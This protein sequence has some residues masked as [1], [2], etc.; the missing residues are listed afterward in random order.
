MGKMG[1]SM[2][3]FNTIAIAFTVCNITSNLVEQFC[4]KK[5]N[6]CQSMTI[7]I[8]QYNYMLSMINF[9]AGPL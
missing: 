1:V 3:F 2:L 4:L 6:V 9:P 7:E 5:Q 8:S